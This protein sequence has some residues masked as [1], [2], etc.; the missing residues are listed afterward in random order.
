MTAILETVQSPSTQKPNP[1][2]LMQI[3]MGFWASKTILAAVK[4]NLF[5]RLGDRKLTPEEIGGELGL[6]PRG[7]TDFLDVLAALGILSREDG[8]YAN[9]LD[10]GFFLVKESP[11]YLGDMLLMANDRLWGMWGRLEEGLKTGLPQNETRENGVSL[12][13]LLYSDSVK[14]DLFLKAMIGLS[15]GTAQAVVRAFDFSDVRKLCDIGGGPGMLSAAVTQTHPHVECVN[16]DLPPVEPVF[17][18]YIA[19]FGLEG[20]IRFQ[21]GDCL[22]DSLPPADVYVMGNLLH[23][24]GPQERKQML[25]AAYAALPHGGRLLIVEALIDDARKENVFGLLM[26]LDMQLETPEGRNFTGAEVRQWLKDAGFK[27]TQIV[28][29][30]GPQSLAVGVKAH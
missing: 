7:T 4:L 10:S 6:N 21:G 20:R 12:L 15:A 23:G 30:N 22:K 13:D 28:S 18:E 27:H 2:R 16:F 14:R 9:T 19:R 1:D 26:S 11:A 25:D 17:N 5:T 8:R 29:L 3:A 24:S